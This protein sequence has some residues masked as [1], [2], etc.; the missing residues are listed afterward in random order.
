MDRS[1]LRLSLQGA[2]EWWDH[3]PGHPNLG[4]KASLNL[5]AL[6]LALGAGGWGLGACRPWS[7]V[8]DLGDLAASLALCPHPGQRCATATLVLVTTTSVLC[9]PCHFNPRGHPGQKGLGPSFRPL[10]KESPPNPQHTAA[11]ALPLSPASCLL[12]PPLSQPGV[13]NSSGVFW[14]MAPKSRLVPAVNLYLLQGA[15]LAPDSGLVCMFWARSL[16]PSG[17]LYKLYHP[18]SPLPSPYL[19]GDLSHS[20]RPLVARTVERSR[21]FFP[22]PA[23]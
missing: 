13:T 12:S 5:P 11:A 4:L 21:L 19:A 8:V 20:H 9:S 3:L 18:C 7:L 15:L 1:A 16:C 23:L 17:A 2:L 10:E 6:G 22:T 14:V